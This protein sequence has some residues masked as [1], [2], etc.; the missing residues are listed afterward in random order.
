M[1]FMKDIYQ[2]VDGLY[3]YEPRIGGGCLYAHHLRE[4]ADMLDELNGPWQKE[5]AR[6][7][8]ENRAVQGLEYGEGVPF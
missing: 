1:N 8:L 6:Y 5:I 4:I 7:E 3:V 2:E